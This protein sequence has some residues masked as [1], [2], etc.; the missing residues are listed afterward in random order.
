MKIDF[1]YAIRNLLQFNTCSRKEEVFDHWD[2][3]NIS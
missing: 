1:S 3:T 2:D